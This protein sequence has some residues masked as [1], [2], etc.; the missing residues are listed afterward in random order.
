MNKQ[1]FG[2]RALLKGLGYAGGL[3]LASHALPSLAA[4]AGSVG[5]E[6]IGRVDDDEKAGELNFLCWEGYDD[7]SIG[8]PFARQYDNARIRYQLVNSDPDAVN[9]LRGG[10][11]KVFDL[12]NLNN[13]WANVMLRIRLGV[14]PL[15]RLGRM[16]LE[17]ALK[18][19]EA[20][21]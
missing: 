16:I 18:P 9:K 12:V 10:Q 13:P 14:C 17:D 8:D 3:G 7:P 5:G 2:R 15:I 20:L 21:V 1:P 6:E 4:A 19:N 11:D